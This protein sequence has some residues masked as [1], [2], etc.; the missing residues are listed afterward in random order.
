[1]SIINRH[2]IVKILNEYAFDN[3]IK[4]VIDC[5]N[6]LL[7]E[8]QQYKSNL[9]LIYMAIASTQMYGFLSYLSYDEQ[10]LFFDCDY[11]RSNSYRGVE[12]PFYNRGQLSFLYELDSNKKVFFSAP[13]S[14][15]K[16]SIVTEYILNNTDKLDNVVF[17]VPTNSLLEELFEKF[18]LYNAK[19]NLNYNISTQPVYPLNGRN[20]LFLT[21]ERFMVIAETTIL[22][23]FDLIVMDETY[24]IVDANNEKISD[25]VNHRALRFRKVA[26]IIAKTDTRV[27]F[28]SPFTYT[29][30]KSMSDF[31]AKHNIKKIDR[32]LEYVKRQTL[33]LHSSNDA[34]N[35]FGKRM[36]GYQSDSSLTKKTK[37]ILSKL[38][39]SNSIVY[40]PNYSKA[41]EIANNIDFSCLNNEYDSRY[42]AFLKHIEENFLV[43]NR[44]TWAVYDALRNGIGIYISPLPRYIKKEIIK[45]YDRKVL[46][47]LIVTS[48][49]TEGVNTCASNL[50]FTSLV[51]G[52]NTNKL[53]D[54]DVLN[55]SGRAGRFAKNTIGR[56]FCVTDDIYN[57]VLELQNANDVKLEN[58]NYKKGSNKLDY[59][60]EMMEDEYLSESQKEELNKQKYE[61]EKLGLTKAELN[62]SLNVSNNWKL[63][64]Y[65]HFKKLSFEEIEVIHKN[66][67][68]VFEQK[69]GE[70]IFAL[71]NIFKDLREAFLD[72]YINIFPQE[73]YEIS[74][75]DKS[76]NFTWGRLYQ[77]YVSGSP[78]MIIKN[79]INFITSKFSDIVQNK[80]YS[81]KKEI[82]GLFEYHNAKWVLKYYNNDLSLNMN[83]FYAETFKIVSNIIQYKIPYYL[84]FY[85]SI[86]KLYIQKNLGDNIN[87]MDFDINRLINIFEDRETS[88]EYSKLIDYGIPISTVNKISS[89]KI[90]YEDLKNDNYNSNFFDEYE[91]IIIKETIRLL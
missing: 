50:I 52:P 11:F 90:S 81:N 87:D 55:V 28:L 59:E 9:D 79:N 23:D 84:T 43:E 6:Q 22:N 19:L 37:L 46:S 82:E 62:I 14:F 72:E 8:K 71:E 88:E 75:F 17:I 21:P 24:K 60:I 1:M 47:T 29:L 27:V 61:I 5:L 41:Y 12:M 13:T 54:I 58:Y 78:K 69:E 66:I 89:N 4:P 15:G 53:S 35:Y 91:N 80:N 2:D 25:F 32:Q 64:L 86:F 48:A 39:S 10:Q 49:F 36:I 74:P 67:E 3:N 38:R 77:I 45:L 44:D 83:T 85:V 40:V 34:K 26:D 56:I 76:N 73:Y 57:R 68:A 63:V 30:T 51:N 20:I 33:K 42:L 70:R 16:T 18:T 7:E 31:L 65:K